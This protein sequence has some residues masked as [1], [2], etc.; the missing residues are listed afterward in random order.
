[1]IRFDVINRIP[2]K[3]RVRFNLKTGHTYTDEKTQ[4]DL[5]LVAES[6]KGKFYTCPVAIIA[7]VYKQQPKA[8]VKHG[9]EPFDCKPD[10]DNVLKALMDGLNGVAYMDDKQVTA[11]YIRKKDRTSSAGEYVK[12]AVVPTSLI[13]GVLVDTELYDEN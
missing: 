2:V 8:N 12:Y 9:P 10:L 7:F 3:R 5:K 1:M 11:A 4:A 6:Y 13:T